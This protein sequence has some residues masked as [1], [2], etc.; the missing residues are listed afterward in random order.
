[1]PER[2]DISGAGGRPAVPSAGHSRPCEGFRMTAHRDDR[3]GA[4][5][6]RPKASNEGNRG[7]SVLRDAGLDR[8]HN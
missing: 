3:A 8:Q 4:G 5:G 1:M 7:E 6:R 2:A